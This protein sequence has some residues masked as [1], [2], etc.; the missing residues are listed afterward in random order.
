MNR[1]TSNY[2]R[3]ILVVIDSVGIGAL[4]DAG[5]YGDNNANT[6]GNIAKTMGGIKLENLQDLGLG[7][8]TE[9]EGVSPI[10]TPS[11]YCTKAK[12]KSIG[13]D[14]LTGHWEMMGLEITSPFQTFTN[15]GFPE[16]LIKAIEA[17][18]SRKVIGNKSSSGTVILDEL[19]EQHLKTGDLIVYTSADS[20]LQ[21]AA[22]EDIIPAKELHR[23]CESVRELTMKEEWKV[24]RIIARPF[25][26][27]GKGKFIR[28]SNRH[29][30]SIE[31]FGKTVLDS[32]IDQ[33]INVVSIGK[34]N[35]IFCGRG[36]SH[37]YGSISNSDG[38]DQL[39]VA[40]E[41][42]EDGLLFLNLVDFDAKYGHRRDP[43]GYGKCLE[44]FDLRLKEV[45]ENLNAEDLLVI[46]AD[47]GN[48]PTFK[49]SDHTREFVPVLL[50]NEAF[51]EPSVLQAL[52][53]FADIG[54]TI[55]DNFGVENPKLGMS[56][57]DILK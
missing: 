55:A 20:V 21:I 45:L 41:K 52:E 28:T 47:H 34:I 24:A 29:D 16:E 38:M 31:P 27:S 3:I 17:I 36:I 2:K 48:D 11:G 53:T 54:A 15:T 30:Y 57:L 46:T 7:N 33:N 14:T 32:M 56:L 12:E 5:L 26:G 6:L 25:I 42:F 23:I 13:K 50:Y 9:I 22:H 18:T 19:G 10:L 1:E 35:D 51:K 43:V 39:I 49:G 44:A 4:P 37:H 8:L 40:M